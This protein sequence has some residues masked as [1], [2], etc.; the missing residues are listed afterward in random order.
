MRRLIPLLLLTLSFTAAAQAPMSNADVV[1]MVDAGLSEQLIIATIRQAPAKNFDTRPEALIDLK[2]K[3]VPDGVILAM[4]GGPA[5]PAATPGASPS[6]PASNSNDPAQ[7]HERGIYLDLGT[8]SSPRLV[9]LT[10]P[11]ITGQKV[12]GLGSS[13]MM[14]AFGG[15]KTSV[16]YEVRGAKSQ[17]RTSSNP[18]TFYFYGLDPEDYPLM[19]MNV[20]G[21][22]REFVGLRLSHGFAGSSQKGAKPDVEVKIEKIGEGI[23]SATPVSALK[24]GEYGF[25]Q[26]VG[27]I[28]EFAIDK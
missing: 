18:P 25:A 5:P 22:G 2:S 8:A 27:G 7:M 20:K 4:V 28:Y 9:K 12:G 6:M 15:A 13:M 10:Q 11:K 17:I 1:K 23:A 3:K 16:K 24:P 19:T 14:G 21:D 26:G